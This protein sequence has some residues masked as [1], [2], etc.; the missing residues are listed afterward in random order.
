MPRR[1][2][3]RFVTYAAQ[4][5]D[6]LPPAGRAALDHRL[7]ELEEDPRQ[8]AEYK[9]S[10]VRWSTTFGRWGVILYLISDK[11][12]TVTVLRITWAGE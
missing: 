5:R 1:Y 7:R 12:V 6:S 9:T 4:Q 2:T 8:G 3:V 11:I 10:D